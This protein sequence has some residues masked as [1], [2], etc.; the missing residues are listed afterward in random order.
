MRRFS[1]FVTLM[2]S[3]VAAL[4]TAQDSV[5]PVMY[6]T[7][8]E[9]L[10]FCEHDP[11]PTDASLEDR[12]LGSACFHYILG[13]AD[14][15]VTLQVAK[16]LSKESIC[17]PQGVETNQLRLV[18]LK[19]LRANPESLHAP[20]ASHVMRALFDSFP[21]GASHDPSPP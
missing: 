14:T 9:L 17:I 3:S 6:L 19:H 10:R 1:A 11:M 12:V 18:V 4:A 21:C 8:N 13:V 7:G 16:T 20:G 15:F 5:S 2:V